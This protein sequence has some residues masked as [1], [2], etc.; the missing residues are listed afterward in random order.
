MAF[1]YTFQFDLE[2]RKIVPSQED[3][4]GHYAVRYYKN[5]ET[6]YIGAEVGDGYRH[7]TH[8]EARHWNRIL[9][10][11][12]EELDESGIEAVAE[13]M[14]GLGADN[15]YQGTFVSAVKDGRIPEI[16]Y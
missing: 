13:L 4:L 3:T 9:K 12:R 7:E 10:M 15:Q 14:Y 1:E 8:L 6:G 16:E 2:R 11:I 5:T